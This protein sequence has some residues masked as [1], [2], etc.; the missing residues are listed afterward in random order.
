MK[1]EPEILARAVVTE[2][3]DCD[4]CRFLMDTSC[5]FFPELYRLW[6]RERDTGEKITSGQLRAL[7][8]RCNFCALCPCP[9]VREKILR[10][11]GAFIER[12]GLPGSVR[13]L[14]DVALLGRVCGTF[15]R[16]TRAVF[17]HGGLGRAARRVLGI[18]GQ[19]TL[20]AFPKTDFFRWAE[21]QGLCHRPSPKT[22]RNVA[23]FAGCTAGYLFP[24]VAQAA[25]EVLQACGV[26][27]WVPPQRCCGMPT[28]L[29][30]DRKQTLRSVRENLETLAAA[31]SAGFDIVCSCPTCGYFLRTLLP[32]GAYYTEAYQKSVGAGARHIMV[33]DSTSRST[34]EPARSFHRYDRAIY[35]TLFKDEGI[36]SGIDA[37]Q[38]IS[39]AEAT[40]DLGAYLLQLSEEELRFSTSSGGSGRILYFPPCHQREQKIGRPYESLLTRIEGL[41]LEPIHGELY[42]C[43]MAGIM[44]FKAAFHDASLQLGRRLMEKIRKI[45]P[46]R[47]VTDCLSCRLQFEQCLSYPVRHP[48][49][50]IR[51]AMQTG[52]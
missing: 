35:D 16:L 13:V 14:E 8:D 2:C 9:P 30:G 36:F 45:Q 34:S 22:G 27:V 19:R 51:D 7:V 5:L 25:V 38:R 6:D 24:E 3:A 37:M 15:P 11:K 20:P 41:R 33:P 44:G 40:Q 32:E 12:D 1:D 18:H 31:V 26:A 29:E 4:I 28:L 43:G 21:K 17:R 52:H 23:Y 47:I 46:E 39:V 42:C 48:V 49:E 50:M 10:A